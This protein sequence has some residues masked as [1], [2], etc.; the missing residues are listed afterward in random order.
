MTK[1][2]LMT[3][4]SIDAH[5][6]YDIGLIEELHPP[7]AFEDAIADVA[8]TL[9]DKPTYI[10]GLAKR[11]VHAVRPLN[12]EEAMQQAINHAIA[13]YHEDEAQRRVTE[14]LDDE[15]G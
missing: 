8:A 1:Y 12:K 5:R 6:A 7:D 9:A 15:A 13:A 2:L 11:Q 10:H 4:E 14:F 3:G